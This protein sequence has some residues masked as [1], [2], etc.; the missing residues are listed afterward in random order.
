MTWVSALG[1]AFCPSRHLLAQVVSIYLT[2]YRPWNTERPEGITTYLP[3]TQLWWF[4]TC[5]L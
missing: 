1:P 3:E 2:S 5:G 4:S